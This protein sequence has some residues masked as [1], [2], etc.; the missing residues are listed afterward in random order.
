MPRN[1]SKRTLKAMRRERRENP[2]VETLLARR[3]RES[4]EERSVREQAEDLF[5]RFHAEGVTW[6][7]AV[8]AVRTNWVASLLAKHE[9]RRRDRGGGAAPDEKTRPRG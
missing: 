4:P 2:P 7:A 3:S 1:V 8:Q 9:A 6:A 5:R